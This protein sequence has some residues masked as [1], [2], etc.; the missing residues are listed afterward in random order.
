M[1]QTVSRLCV[2]IREQKWRS[3][4][5]EHTGLD[6]AIAEGV[7]RGI[8]FGGNETGTVPNVRKR[9]SSS[10]EYGRRQEKKKA[11]IIC[12]FVKLRSIVPV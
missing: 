4:S 8:E 6:Q 12:D 7:L 11:R 3:A 5:V 9:M 2:C 10:Y 1:G